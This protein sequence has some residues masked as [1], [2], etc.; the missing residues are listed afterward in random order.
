VTVDSFM[1]VANDLRDFAIPIDLLEDPLANNWVCLHLSALVECERTRLL[2]KTR[3]K[4]YLPD[5]MNESTDVHELLVSGIQAHA[6]R[7]VSSVDRDRGGVPGCVLIAC[8][9]RGDQS[10]GEGQIRT[11]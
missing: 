8:I 1:V 3:L 9:Q 7:N 10:R 5:V 4:T 6:L 2:E 11:L